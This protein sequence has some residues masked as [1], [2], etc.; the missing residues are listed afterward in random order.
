MAAPKRAATFGTPETSYEADPHALALEQAHHLRAGAWSALD[1]A[2]LADE[3]EDVA[4]SERRLLTS[5]FRIILLHLLKWD[6][7][8]ERRTRSWTTSIRTH[9]LAVLYQL[10]DCPSL[11]SQIPDRIER[12]YRRARIDAS[13][14]TDLD[15]SLFAEDL[16]YNYDE[17]ITRPVS[18]PPAP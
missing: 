15:E 16:P 10:E 11:A 13:G 3:I 5:A 8:P 6:N 17:I 2:N 14:E 1:I 12:A 18:W 4:D 9:R 7:Q